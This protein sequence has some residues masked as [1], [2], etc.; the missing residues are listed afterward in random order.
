[1]KLE[2]IRYIERLDKQHKVIGCYMPGNF[3]VY[4]RTM[5]NAW[6]NIHQNWH[7][8][9]WKVK[10]SA[11][12][13][14]GRDYWSQQPYGGRLALGR[15]VKFFITHDMLPISL[16]VANAGKKGKRQYRPQ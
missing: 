7:N 15:C 9:N 12:E 11:E 2:D 5:E 1:M 14:I 16:K 4:R 8:V 13:L 6:K 10:Q 3:W